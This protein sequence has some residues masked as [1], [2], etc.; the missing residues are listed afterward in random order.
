MT[1]HPILFM[2]SLQGMYWDPRNSV[3]ERHAEEDA[4]T[5]VRSTKKPLLDLHL[6]WETRELKKSCLCNLGNQR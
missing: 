4:G 1:T 2:D 3:S 6:L 5:Q